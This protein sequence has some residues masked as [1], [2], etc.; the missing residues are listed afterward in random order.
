[1]KKGPI[2]ILTEKPRQFKVKTRNLNASVDGEE[3]Y[4]TVKENK[5]TERELASVDV[6]EGSVLVCNYDPEI[7]LD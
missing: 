2:R 4:V 5:N 7:E 6:K 1:M 3:F